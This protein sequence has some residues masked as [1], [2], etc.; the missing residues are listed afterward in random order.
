MTNVISSILDYGT[1]ASEST[2]R[3]LATLKKAYGS[4][5][6]A[7]DGNQAITNLPFTS[8]ATYVVFMSYLYNSTN[9]WSPVA[10]K[11]SG[12]QFT[13]YN[14]NGARTMMWFAI[15]T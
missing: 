5:A 13:L 6:F 2:A 11:N 8:A 10:I 14:N 1:S 3:T 12:A 7:G 9:S 15:G 4:F